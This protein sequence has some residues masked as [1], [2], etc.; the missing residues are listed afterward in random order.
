MLTLPFNNY[1][2]K[3]ISKINKLNRSSIQLKT[4]NNMQRNGF[5]AGKINK[6]ATPPDLL[7]RAGLFFKKTYNSVLEKEIGQ[8]ASNL[9]NYTGKAIISPLMIFT[10]APFTNEK[11]DSI[12]NSAVLHPIQAVLAFASSLG[13]SVITNKIL[14]H[15]A[16]KGTLGNFIDP[17][18]GNFFNPAKTNGKN[19]LAKLKN[20]STFF[21]TII[22]IPFAGILLNK[23]LPKIIKTDK[24]NQENHAKKGKLYA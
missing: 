6:S 19:N 10:I 21:L 12:R 13:A 23:I 9:I 15:Q 3:E 20:I 4:K 14:D 17:E 18:L 5:G 1:I 7:K 11:K 16:K 24:T 22:A 2:N 8:T